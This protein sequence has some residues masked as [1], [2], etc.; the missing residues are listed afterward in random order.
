MNDVRGKLISRL[1]DMYNARTQTEKTF[2]CNLR[3]YTDH[4]K[5]TEYVDILTEFRGRIQELEYVLT[6]EEVEEVRKELGISN[7]LN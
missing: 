6:I 3:F 4:A 1:R 7:K 5:I 2:V